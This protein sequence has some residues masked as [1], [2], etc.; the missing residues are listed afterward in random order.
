MI[1]SRWSR[2]FFWECLVLF[3]IPYTRGLMFLP[4]ASI[5]CRL[6]FTKLLCTRVYNLYNILYGPYNYICMH[7]NCGKWLQYQYI[8]SLPRLCWYRVVYFFSITNSK[9][10]HSCICRGLEHVR[11]HLTK[12]I[13]VEILY[14]PKMWLIY[15]TNK[16]IICFRLMTIPRTKVPSK[17]NSARKSALKM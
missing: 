15:C 4:S 1:D 8:S 9:R 10:Y 12:Q 14:Y 7:F 13:K 17:C 16:I 3:T 6:I 11:H 2:D 5:M